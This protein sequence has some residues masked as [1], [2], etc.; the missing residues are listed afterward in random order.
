[1]VIEREQL[2][3]LAGIEHDQNEVSTETGS[4]TETPSLVK[5]VV[6]TSQEQSIENAVVLRGRTEAARSVIVRT[7]T[8]GS[9]VSEPLRKGSYVNEGDILC[10]ISQGTRVATVNEAK[11]RII[12]AEASVPQAE[13][14]LKQS[15]AQLREAEVNLKAART[16]EEDGYATET[17][18]LASEA[19]LGAALA[20][21]EAARG[22][23]IS[24]ETSIVSAR[25]A[26]ANAELELTRIEIRA[27]FSGLLETDTAELGSFLSTGADCATVIQLDTVK[28]V[29]FVPELDV[30]KISIGA[31]AKARLTNDREIEGRVTFLSRSADQT[32]RTFRTEI[33]VQN[34]DLSIRDGQTAD[35]IIGSTGRLAHLVPQSA[36]TLNDE[37]TLG[38]RSIDDNNI[39]VFNKVEIIRDTTN[40][41]WVTGLPP[42]IDIIVLGHEYVIKGVEVDPTF[43]ESAG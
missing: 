14:N 21:V 40:G 10:K 28:L 36:L 35:I 15:E 22:G 26:L 25:A 2:F 19:A 37:G 20:S 41:I 3:A 30:N 4:I 42:L 17:R 11:A 8:S 7:E 34:K 38:L 27:P 33:E 24:A 29:G 31:P 23:L 39:V 32:T 43:Q 13:A 5:V 1:M 16:L 18:L 6:Q 9:V 12:Q